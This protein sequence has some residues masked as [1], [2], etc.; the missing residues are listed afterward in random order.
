MS[1]IAE[2]VS[3]D[4]DAG[5]EGDF[6][7]FLPDPSRKL[8]ITPNCI[9]PQHQTG[10]CWR[11][12]KV[13]LPKGLVRQDLHDFPELWKPVQSQSTTSLILDDRLMI[14]ASDRFWAADYVVMRADHRSVQLNAGHL[15]WS[16]KD[17]QLGVVWE[18]E[19]YEVEWTGFG[20]TVFQKGEAGRNRT[21]LS[22]GHVTVE[23]AKS[24]ARR[25]YVGRV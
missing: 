6:K 25:R 19:K 21:K 2:K 11:E 7:K 5:R 24:D 20:Y 17:Y 10:L 13:V 16:G 12:F 8:P 9:R 3:E 22:D 4:E 14:V 18:D 15:L 23:N 1:E